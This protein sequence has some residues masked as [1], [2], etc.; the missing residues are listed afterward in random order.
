[1]EGRITWANAVS[2]KIEWTEGEKVTWKRGSLAT[3]PIEILDSEE[4]DHATATPADTTAPAAEEPPR[5][6]R[7]GQADSVHSRPAE[8]VHHIHAR[9]RTG[10][11]VTAPSGPSRGRHGGP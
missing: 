5:P 8:E 6:S 7:V 9:A 2:V 1:A 3:R 10:R 4:Q 11:R